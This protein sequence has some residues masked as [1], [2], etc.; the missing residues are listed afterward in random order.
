MKY[1]KRKTCLDIHV[2]YYAW[3]IASSQDRRTRSSHLV[4]LSRNNYVRNN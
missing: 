3:H 1:F 2:S 4:R